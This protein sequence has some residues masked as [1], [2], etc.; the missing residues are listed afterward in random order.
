MRRGVTIEE[1][2]VAG[3]TVQEDLIEKTV[4]VNE[5]GNLGIRPIDWMPSGPRA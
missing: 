2:I 1:S 5:D 4:D 3:G